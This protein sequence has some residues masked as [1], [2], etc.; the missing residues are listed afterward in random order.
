M[1]W[2]V[3]ATVAV[4]L[5]GGGGGS[6]GA[7]TGSTEAS[8]AGA[9][10]EALAG[11]DDATPGAAVAGVLE[12]IARDEGFAVPATVG[13]PSLAEGIAAHADRLGVPAPLPPAGIPGKLDAALGC[14]LGAVDAANRAHDATFADVPRDRVRAWI[15]SGTE[16]S[17]ELEAALA[18][19]DHGRLVV[20]AAQAARALDQALTLLEDLQATDAPLGPIDLR[21]ILRF[22]PG[23]DQF[24]VD[25]YAVLVDLEGDDTYD[26]HAGGVFAAV[27]NAIYDVDNAKAWLYQPLPGGWQ[28]SVGGDVQDA[29]FVVSSSLVVDRDGNDVYGVKHAPM[30]KDLEEGCAGEPVVPRV[31]TLGGGIMGVG[32]LFDLGGDNLYIGRTQTQGAG[33]ILGV[34][35]LYTGAGRDTFEAIRAAQ[36]SGLLGGVG[37]LVDRDGPSTYTLRSPPLGVFNGDLT[38][39]D[40][41]LRYAQGSSFDRR[42]GPGPTV[43]GILADLGG[44]DRYEAGTLAQGFGQGPGFGLL[45]E[46][47]G[48]DRYSADDRSQGAA[49]GRSADLNPQAIPGGGLALLLDEAGEDVYTLG[50]PRGQGWSLGTTP[51]PPPG[52]NLV[53]LVDWANAQGK[54]TAVA[55]LRDRAGTDA[56]AGPPGRADGAVLTDGV[57]GVFVDES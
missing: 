39:C 15:E 13:C 55:V 16:G 19:R 9:S 7:S 45:Y 3:A 35:V 25:N 49:Q 36:G 42:T 17:P 40:D 48:N 53:D 22:E 18:G 29:D 10:I 11:A 47:G 12:A 24:Y 26:N 33:H 51:G 28:A 43:V 21:P 14:L 41:G 31:G 50:S 46:A 23:G 34:G 1:R 57:V 54:N 38:I 5:A 32:M 52:P 4:L 30:F 20:A 8:G 27:G 2:A 56:Y 44:D 6:A 37:L